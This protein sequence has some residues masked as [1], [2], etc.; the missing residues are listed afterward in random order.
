MARIILNSK[1]YSLYD[2]DNEADFEKAVIENQKYL[3]GKDSIYVDVKK[4]IGKDNQK[5]IPDA[6]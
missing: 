5:G 4:K 1:E 6:F 2:F 3:F